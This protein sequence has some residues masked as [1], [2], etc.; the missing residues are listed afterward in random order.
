[1][2]KSALRDRACSMYFYG[3]WEETSAKVDCPVISLAQAGIQNCLKSRIPSR[4]PACAGIAR[5][6]DPSGVFNLQELQK[7]SIEP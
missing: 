6:D 1:M 4:L 5:N 3:L 7:E 2:S